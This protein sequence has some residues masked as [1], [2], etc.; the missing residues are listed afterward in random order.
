MMYGIVKV[1]FAH[2]Q[3]W[4]LMRAG[5]SRRMPADTFVRQFCL[6]VHRRR[7]QTLK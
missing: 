5:V 3:R 4:G 6:A 1:P 2:L 7:M